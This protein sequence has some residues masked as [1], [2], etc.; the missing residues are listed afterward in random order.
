[1]SHAGVSRLARLGAICVVKSLSWQRFQS[2][3]CNKAG[4]VWWCA[5][6]P[7]SGGHCGKHPSVSRQARGSNALSGDDQTVLRIDTTCPL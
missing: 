3:L 1:M 6:R 4:A 2:L 7:L 5:V